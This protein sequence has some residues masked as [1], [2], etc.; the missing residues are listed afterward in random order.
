LGANTH[1]PNSGKC[2]CA[3]CA[4]TR[5]YDRAAEAAA[6]GDHATAQL[7]QLLGDDWFRIAEQDRARLAAGRGGVEAEP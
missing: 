2:C 7:R 4:A 3:G 6:T 5:N 1:D